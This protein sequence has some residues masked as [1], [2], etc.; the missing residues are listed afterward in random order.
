VIKKKRLKGGLAAISGV[1]WGHQ[2]QLTGH[3]QC[4]AGAVAAGSHSAGVD[5]D[6][7]LTGCRSITA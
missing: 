6:G 2:P 5:E 7:E 3:R 4:Q 1:G